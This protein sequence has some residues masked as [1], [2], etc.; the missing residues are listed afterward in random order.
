MLRGKNLALLHN[1]PEITDIHVHLAMLRQKGGLI[2]D[3]L[4]EFLVNEEEYADFLENAFEKLPAKPGATNLFYSRDYQR[5]ELIAKQIA[6]KKKKKRFI[7]L[8][9]R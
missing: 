2:H 5:L 8:I 4:E 6:K 1:N 7:K 3:A 9:E